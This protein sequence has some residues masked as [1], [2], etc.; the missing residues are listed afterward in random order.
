MTGRAVLDDFERLRASA[1]R[2]VEARISS[3]GATSE[4]ATKKGRVEIGN[5]SLDLVGNLGTF[6]AGW[7]AVFTA[8][9]VPLREA[10][11]TGVAAQVAGRRSQ[12][13]HHTSQVA[14]KSSAGFLD[15]KPFL[16]LSSV[17]Q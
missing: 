3:R 16:R 13:A 8:L 12:D 6:E 15:V 5:A 11:A 4:S 9:G 17:F 7:T 1:V 14:A 2:L 10:A